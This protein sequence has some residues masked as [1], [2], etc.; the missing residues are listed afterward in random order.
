MR[1]YLAD[2]GHIWQR[3]EHKLTYLAFLVNAIQEQCTQH[4]LSYNL[5]I[6]IGLGLAC[7]SD[8]FSGARICSLF[9]S[10][11]V[12]LFH[13]STFGAQ[14]IYFWLLLHKMNINYGHDQISSTNMCHLFFFLSQ[15]I[16][17]ISLTLSC[18]NCEM[19][20]MEKCAQSA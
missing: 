3:V 6:M 9:L 18:Q 20:S 14:E 8:D 10:L 7:L 11:R 13:S 16:N 5:K 19:S 1:N 2:V 17:N 15:N 4:S 12:F